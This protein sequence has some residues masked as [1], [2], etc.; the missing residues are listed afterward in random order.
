MGKLRKL[1][2]FLEISKNLKI[3]LEN[4]KKKKK[5]ELIFFYHLPGIC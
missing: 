5:I 1:E 3:F 2:N 4:L